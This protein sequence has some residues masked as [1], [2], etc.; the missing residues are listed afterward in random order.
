MIPQVG[1]FQGCYLDNHRNNWRCARAVPALCENAP[2]RCRYSTKRRP[3]PVHI[4]SNQQ[5]GL[6]FRDRAALPPCSVAA[7]PTCAVSAWPRIPDH[8]TF[9]PRPHPAGAVAAFS[10]HS[11]LWRSP[12]HPQPFCIH[13]Y[14]SQPAWPRGFFCP[15]QEWQHDIVCLPILKGASTVAQWPGPSRAYVLWLLPRHCF[16][17]WWSPA[18]PPLFLGIEDCLG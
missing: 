18:P 1:G 17:L 3:A 9:Q 11:P 4:R 15:L 10:N 14:I 13:M 12:V 7:L 16:V 8:A 5:E 6:S 2:W